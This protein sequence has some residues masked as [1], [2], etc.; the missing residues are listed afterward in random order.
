M[1]KK[2]NMTRPKSRQQIRTQGQNL[3]LL[4]RET[5]APKNGKAGGDRR[6][7]KEKKNGAWAGEGSP[8]ERGGGMPKSTVL[9]RTRNSHRDRNSN[10]K[11]RKKGGER[12]R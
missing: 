2:P 1:K 6:G 11:S 3:S 4:G 7:K 8:K 5:P 10:K 9:G 12:R